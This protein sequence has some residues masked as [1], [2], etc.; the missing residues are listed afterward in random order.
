MG[1]FSHLFCRKSNTITP[2]D[3]NSAKGFNVKNPY[4]IL[5]IVGPMCLIAANAGDSHVYV[6]LQDENQAKGFLKSVTLLASIDNCSIS[7]TYDATSYKKLGVTAPIAQYLATVPFKTKN[8]AYSYDFEISFTELPDSP[9]SLTD[10][11]INEM[12]RGVSQSNYVKAGVRNVQINA[13]AG[14]LSC[15]ID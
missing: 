11:I 14:V 5:R 7:C 6:A 13:N 4:E 12:R 9:S 1:L 15:S 10:Q 2:S 3:T 8:C